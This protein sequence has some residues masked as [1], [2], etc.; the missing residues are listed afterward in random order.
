MKT[1]G[2]RLLGKAGCSSAKWKRRKSRSFKKRPSSC[3]W[4]TAD[5]H[6]SL[7][8]ILHKVIDAC[9]G[10]TLDDSL[11][12]NPLCS[13]FLLTEEVPPFFPDLGTSDDSS[14]S[15]SVVQDE[16]KIQLVSV[17]TNGKSVF[18]S[19]GHSFF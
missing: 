17:C 7:L 10:K 5:H 2:A 8:S 6:H 15:D 9:P 1:T 18:L 4:S 19:S 14:L 16:G 12:I 13:S 11:M 3:D